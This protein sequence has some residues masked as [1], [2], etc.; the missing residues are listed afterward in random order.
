M[1][2]S[3]IVESPL[4]EHMVAPKNKAGILNQQFESTWTKR[5]KENIPIPDGTQ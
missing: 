1:S 3:G 4:L 2:L 5:D